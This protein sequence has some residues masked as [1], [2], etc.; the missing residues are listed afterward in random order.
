MLYC[1]VDDELFGKKDLNSVLYLVFT[2]WGL[3]KYPKSIPFI[4]V[5]EQN[6]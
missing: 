1:L 3:N 4:K 6:S 5:R 2:Y